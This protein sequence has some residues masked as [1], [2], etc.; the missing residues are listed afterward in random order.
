MPAEAVDPELGCAL[1]E[2]LSTEPSDNSKAEKEKA[3]TPA[4]EKKEG[5]EEDP[6]GK[7]FYVSIRFPYLDMESVKKKLED[8][9]GPVTNEN[10]TNFQG[11]LAWDS[12][13]TL[14]VMWVDR[15]EKRPFCRRITYLDK[16]AV[17]ELNKYVGD[18]F[19]KTELE[20]IAKI[21]ESTKTR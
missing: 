20:L 10:L 12:E 16:S 14:V 3:E 8:Q 21:E 11:A 2:P 19:S 9:Y 4:K 15:Y 18:V 13:K 17:K 1:A 5:E 6:G 7:L